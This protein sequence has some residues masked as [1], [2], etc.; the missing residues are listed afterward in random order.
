[1]FLR[2][3]KKLAKRRIPDIK[4]CFRD[5]LFG[6]PSQGQIA[7]ES[8]PRKDAENRGRQCCTV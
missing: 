2:M 5:T 6:F 3:A 8:G 4:G 7:A 1:M